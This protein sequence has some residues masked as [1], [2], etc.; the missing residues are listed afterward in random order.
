M[1][2]PF[3]YHAVAWVWLEYLTRGQDK[4]EAAMAEC[5]RLARSAGVPLH[6]GAN[7]ELSSETNREEH[8]GRT[9]MGE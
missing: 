7:D 5:L 1:T 9:L 2:P 3:M 4:A 6:V 8:I